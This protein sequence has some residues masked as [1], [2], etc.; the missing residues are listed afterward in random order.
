MATLRQLNVSTYE[1]WTNMKT[2]CFSAAYERFDL[3]GGRGITVCARWLSFENFIVDMGPKPDGLTIER[4][5][6]DGN[7]EPG[8]CYWSTR[9]AQARNRRSNVT[10]TVGGVTLHAQDWARRLGV[11]E[12]AFYTRARRVGCE[13]AVR[14]YQQHGV[15]RVAGKNVK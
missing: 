2:R 5:D 7:Y 15:R 1:C 6:N 4:R 10:A 11:S 9:K 14:H 8:N 12:N 3:Y 13:A